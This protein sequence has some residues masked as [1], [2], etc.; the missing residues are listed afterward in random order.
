MNVLF[1]A[2]WDEE[3]KTNIGK[4]LQGQ[5][6]AFEELGHHVTSIQFYDGA[7]WAITSEHKERLF[8]VSGSGFVHLLAI[9]RAVH[10]LLKCGNNYDFS[11]ARRTFCTPWHLKMLRELKKKGVFTIEELPTYPYDDENKLYTKK[12]YKVAALIEKVCRLFYHHW[13]DLFTTLSDD[14][15]IFGVPALQIENGIDLKSISYVQ[16]EYHAGD[17]IHLLTISS[18]KPWHGYDR[19]IQGLADYKESH[20]V[21][22]QRFII[23]MI[24]DGPMK[25]VWEN[26]ANRLH[27]SDQ[28]IFHG[29]QTGAA[30]DIIVNRCQIAVGSLALYKAVQNIQKASTLKNR[31]YLARGIPFVYDLPDS[32]SLESSFSLLIENDK[33]EDT[34][35]DFALFEEFFED[36][37]QEKDISMRMRLFAEKHIAWTSQMKKVVNAVKNQLL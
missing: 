34:P 19:L 33:N 23:E 4:K 24:G 8:H 16:H 21:N 7:V 17:T 32:L 27:I 35:I 12:S 37:V 2:H 25:N 22:A 3:K 13:L 20:P 28:V 31:E 1:I 29:N 6:N 18:M 14:A 10:F 15:E 26:L 9:P 36:L 5:V 11:Y 30:L